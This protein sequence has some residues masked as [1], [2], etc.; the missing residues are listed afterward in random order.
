LVD[1]VVTDENL[2]AAFLLDRAIDA[3]DGR[4]ARV[5]GARICKFGCRWHPRCEPTSIFDAVPTDRHYAANWKRRRC[6]VAVL[7][8]SSSDKSDCLYMAKWARQ[9]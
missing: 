3:R 5:T 2:H 7:L 6:Y 1:V 4:G 8:G 9:R